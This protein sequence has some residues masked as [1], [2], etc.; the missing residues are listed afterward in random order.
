MMLGVEVNDPD[1]KKALTEAC[2]H[3]GLII[4]WFLFQ[5]ATFRIAPPLTITYQEIEKACEKLEKVFGEV[6]SP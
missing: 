5:P 1:I 3:N 6:K 2:L 4:D